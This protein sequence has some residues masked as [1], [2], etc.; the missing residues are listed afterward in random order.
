MK[1]DYRGFTDLAVGLAAIESG[2]LDAIV[3][4]RPLLTSEIADGHAKTLELLPRTSSARTTPS[5]CRPAAPC[6]S[7]S[8]GSS[9]AT[10][11]PSKICEHCEQTTI[12]R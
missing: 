12:Q 4:D 5:P 11:P 7:R 3:F 9:P 1:L 2:E 8:T 10:S 6:A